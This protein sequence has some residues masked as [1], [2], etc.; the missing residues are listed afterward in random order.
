MLSAATRT[1]GGSSYPAA[2]EIVRG[3]DSLVSPAESG[4]TLKHFLGPGRGNP[5]LELGQR[6]PSGHVAPRIRTARCGVRKIQRSR[7][8][9]AP[10]SP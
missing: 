5:G 10:A 4:L 8:I 1:R 7:L 2:G 9:M 3:W 6:R